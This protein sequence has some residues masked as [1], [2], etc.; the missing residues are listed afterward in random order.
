MSQPRLIAVTPI[1]AAG[2]FADCALRLAQIAARADVATVM[3]R[4][5]PGVPDL[6]LSPMTRFAAQHETALLVV[7]DADRAGRAGFDGAHC[8][9]DEAALKA[10][11]K[12]LKPDRIVGAGGFLERDG[13][14]IAGELGADY[15]M[16]GKDGMSAHEARIAAGL[17]EWWVDVMEPPCAGY[18]ATLEALSA[19]RKAAADFIA[20][21]PALWLT[22]ETF[23]LTLD[24]LK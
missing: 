15:V 22:D 16:F 5:A 12:W 2:Q 11:L 7:G 3:L 19:H 14:M 10:A 1:L 4:L 21:D 9:G 24:A 6:S 8:E 17:V 18:A 20:L 13:A 23:A